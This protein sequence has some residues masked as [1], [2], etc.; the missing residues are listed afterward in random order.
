MS[1][2]I[3]EQLSTLLH[4][5]TE[6]IN[7]GEARIKELEETVA[8]QLESINLLKQ[9]LA[10]QDQEITKLTSLVEQKEINS[11]RMENHVQKLAMRC[12]ELSERCS[13]M[14]FKDPGITEWEQIKNKT[15]QKLTMENL[16][17]FKKIGEERSKF[18]LEIECLKRKIESKPESDTETECT[19]SQLSNIIEKPDLT[20]GMDS[21]KSEM[22]SLEISDLPPFKN[23]DNLDTPK[24]SNFKEQ[25]KLQSNS[26]SISSS[27]NGNERIS[28]INSSSTI[29]IIDI[30]SSPFDLLKPSPPIQISNPTTLG[31]KTNSTTPVET[32]NLKRSY[33]S[34]TPRTADRPTFKYQEVVRDKETRRKMHG[35]DCSCCTDYY[36]LTADLKPLRELGA[37]HRDRR[38]VISRHRDWS[39]KPDTPPWYWDVDFPTTQEIESTKKR[40]AGK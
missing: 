15:I 26:K 11:R 5:N 2:S 35:R 27:A 4:S 36:R 39:K 6:T 24:N 38:Q 29:K 7:Q 8:G 9:R 23:Q 40:K 31:E 34:T 3:L 14:K 28:P 1:H 19:A 30:P 21:E 25:D 13:L 32:S 17:L 37:A 10:H 12:S 22:A 20:N 33:S 16:K 18:N